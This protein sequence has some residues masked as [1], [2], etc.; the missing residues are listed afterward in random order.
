[1][2]RNFNRPTCRHPCTILA[3]CTVGTD[4]EITGETTGREAVNNYYNLRADMT[5]TALLSRIASR[6][7]GLL[8]EMNRNSRPNAPGAQTA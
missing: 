7:Y 6:R 5:I 4:S 2:T 3:N 1:M 8:A